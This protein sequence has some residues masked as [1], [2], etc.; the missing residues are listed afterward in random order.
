MSLSIEEMGEALEDAER[1]L[2]RADAVTGR[3]ARMMVGRLRNAQVSAYTLAALKRELADFNMH[4]K[5]WKQ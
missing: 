2:K 3:M 1:T 4:T 5:S